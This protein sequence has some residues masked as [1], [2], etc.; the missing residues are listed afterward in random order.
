MALFLISLSLTSCGIIGALGRTA[1]KIL[2]QS[3]DDA[4]REAM[5]ES[6]RE[7]EA[8]TPPAADSTP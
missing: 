1:N 5:F 2:Y 7:I 4:S 3:T 8:I 6:L